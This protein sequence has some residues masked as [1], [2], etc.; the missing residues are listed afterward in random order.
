M[1]IIIYKGYALQSF[2]NGAGGPGGGDSPLGLG[3]SH[4]PCQFISNVVNDSLY[5]VF[6]GWIFYGNV[7]IIYLFKTWDVY[8]YW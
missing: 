3:A 7:I 2:H 5:I 6:Y 4:P 8:Y 1:Y